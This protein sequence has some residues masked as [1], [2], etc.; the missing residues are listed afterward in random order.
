MGLDYLVAKR[1][2]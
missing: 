1:I 2:D